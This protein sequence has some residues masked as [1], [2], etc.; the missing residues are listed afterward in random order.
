MGQSRTGRSRP[1][2]ASSVDNAG[3]GHRRPPPTQRSTTAHPDGRWRGRQAETPDPAG[4]GDD[5]NQHGTIAATCGQIAQNFR[6]LRWS[7]W[8]RLHPPVVHSALRSSRTGYP[9]IVLRGGIQPGNRH[10]VIIL[11]SLHRRTRC[12]VRGEIPPAVTSGWQGDSQSV[13][14]TDFSPFS[15]VSTRPENAIGARFRPSRAR[16]ENRLRINEVLVPLP[17]PPGHRALLVRLHAPG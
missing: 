6:A 1:D 12:I 17:V 14:V 15:Q 16:S 3:S 2:W 10:R 7:L 9:S 4:Q 11:C 13:Y 8:R 5:L